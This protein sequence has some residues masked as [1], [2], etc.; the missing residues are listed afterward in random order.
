MSAVG[1]DGGSKLQGFDQDFKNGKNLRLKI[2]LLL[3]ILL[4]SPKIC[5]DPVQM[6]PHKMNEA[7]F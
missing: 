3:Q 1:T 7:D 6:V 2:L 4:K 5:T